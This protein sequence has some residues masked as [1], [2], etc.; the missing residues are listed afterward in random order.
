[1]RTCGAF[2]I[3]F[4]SPWHGQNHLLKTEFGKLMAMACSE[5]LPHWGVLRYSTAEVESCAVERGFRRQ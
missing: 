2:Q 4:C 5:M 1:M 3:G